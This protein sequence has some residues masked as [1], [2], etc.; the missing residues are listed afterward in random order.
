MDHEVILNEGD[1]ITFVTGKE[2]KGNKSRIYMN[3]DNFP[4]D[5]K[6][7]ERI[8]LDDGKLIFEVV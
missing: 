2:F 5:V 7:G 1:E 3:Y 8:L 4:N 6:S